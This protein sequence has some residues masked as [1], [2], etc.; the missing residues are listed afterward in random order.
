MVYKLDGLESERQMELFSPNTTYWKVKN[1]SPNSGEESIQRK[2]RKNIEKGRGSTG[3]RT[4]GAIERA[5]FWW[6]EGSR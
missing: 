6:D 3:T 2:N 4:E 1:K 5:V